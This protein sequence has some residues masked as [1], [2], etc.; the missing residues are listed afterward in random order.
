MKSARHITIHAIERYQQRVCPA[1][2]NQEA[3][4]AV[5]RLALSSRRRA[6][7]RAWM[8]D[9]PRSAWDALPISRIAARRVP[10]HAR[11]N[12]RDRRYA[13]CVTCL[14]ATGAPAPRAAA[15]RSAPALALGR[16]AG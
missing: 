15:P 1:V 7:P 2:S 16:R 12:D 3:R 4:L 6:T 9:R 10:D 11:R 13:R 5:L 14:L 8:R